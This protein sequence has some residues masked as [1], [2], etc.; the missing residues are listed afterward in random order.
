MS[1]ETATA[2]VPALTPTDIENRRV[3]RIKD[4]EEADAKQREEY[5]KES[6]DF[7]EKLQEKGCAAQVARLTNTKGESVE[8]PIIDL[9]ES[10]FIRAAF[11]TEIDDE[12]ES[13][14]FEILIP[15]NRATIAALQDIAAYCAIYNTAGTVP[16][17][18]K[19]V[20]SSDMAVVAGEVHGSFIEAIKLDREN[21]NKRIF[22]LIEVANFME[23]IPLM[24]LACAAVASLMKDKPN[25]EIETM[26]G[27]PPMTK[28]DE[29]EI[30]KEHA[31]LMEVIDF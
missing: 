17:I 1:T 18:E 19:P 9:A 16:E 4:R 23:L 12:G 29:E 25:E 28:K 30:M 8:I 22:D 27:R 15:N 31:S 13:E 21:Y 5:M 20:K 24:N 2:S 14:A 26:F 10:G 6:R 11:E 7:V 3:K